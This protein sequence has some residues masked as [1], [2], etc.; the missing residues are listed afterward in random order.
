[1]DACRVP[2]KRLI[3]VVAS[4]SVVLPFNVVA[5]VVVSVPVTDTLVPMVVASTEAPMARAMPTMVPNAIIEGLRN[6]LRLIILIKKF[7]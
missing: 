3:S 2:V 4:P 1:M 5:P 7:A 6:E